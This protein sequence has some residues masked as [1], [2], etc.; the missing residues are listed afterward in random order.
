[1]TSQDLMK[2]L[3]DTIS[4][5]YYINL[6][7]IRDAIRDEL[8]AEVRDEVRQEL[9]DEIRTELEDAVNAAGEDDAPEI[10]TAEAWGQDDAAGLGSFL[11]YFDQSW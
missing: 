6:D 10:G 7:Q 2:Q 5:L 1:M 9:I 4:A 3:E 8:E 11:R